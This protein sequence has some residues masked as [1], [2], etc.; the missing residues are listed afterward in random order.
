MAGRPIES[1]KVYIIGAGPG[2]AE[3]VTVRGMRIIRQA[4]VILYADSLV[5]EALFS[6]LKPGAEVLKSSG[7]HLEEMVACM[8]ERARAGQVVARVHSGDPSVY[9]AVWEQIHL[10]KRH[11]VPFEIVP[12]VSAAFAAAAAVG[13]ELTVPEVSQTVIFTRTPG[14]ASRMPE[15]A[16]LREVAKIPATLAI[17]LSAA[18]VHRVVSEL[19][20]AGLDEATPVVVAE[21]VSWPDERIFHTT[22][23]DLERTIKSNKITRQAMILVGRA[24]DRELLETGAVPSRL[25]DKTYSHLFRRA[26]G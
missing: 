10:F 6:D 19:R 11:G 12:G 4:D 2:D 15:G 24:L 20:L 13:A 26:K 23:K 22:L 9:G 14:R 5:S 8:V 17:F 18:L 7:M 1:G 16:E 3:L 21:R 25:Y